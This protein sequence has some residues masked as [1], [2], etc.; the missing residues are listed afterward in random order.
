MVW[1]AVRLMI[2]VFGYSVGLGCIALSGTLLSCGVEVEGLSL[3]A[4]DD[5]VE[6]FL[7]RLAVDL[8][9]WRPAEFPVDVIS[10]GSCRVPGWWVWVARSEGIWC[11][12]WSASSQPARAR[13]FCHHGCTG[14]GQ[15][16][17]AA[18]RRQVLRLRA[19]TPLARGRALP[20][21]Q[22]RCGDPGRVR[23]H[24]TVPATLSV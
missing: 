5:A 15:P 19:P 8:L 14:P 18:G 24:A 6:N 3:G 12:S 21:L 9:P 10:T 2:D 23:R 17:G 16:L 7:A 22:Q 20:R 1:R 11:D 4:G 13:S